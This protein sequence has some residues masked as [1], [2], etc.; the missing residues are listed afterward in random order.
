MGTPLEHGEADGVWT[1]VES[2]T[3]RLL[4]TARPPVTYASASM[5]RNSGSS[6]MPA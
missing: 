2:L 3:D 4:E 1:A 6:G 5:A